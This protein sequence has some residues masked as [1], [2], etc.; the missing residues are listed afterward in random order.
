[1]PWWIVMLVTLG[2]FQHFIHSTSHVLKYLWEFPLMWSYLSASPALE[3][4]SF[5]SWPPSSLTLVSLPSLSPSGDKS[6][7]V[8]STAV[9]MFPWTGISLMTPFMFYLNFT[10]S[11]IIFVTLMHFYLYGSF[12]SFFIE[13]IGEALVNKI[14]QLSGVQFYNTSSVCCSVCSLPKVRSPSITFYPSLPSQPSPTSLN[15][16]FWLSIFAKGQ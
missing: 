16:F 15:F 9:L 13:L 1:M 7:V 5:L 12:P 14:I 2:G 10:S 4:S 3:N 11:I 6:R 8:W